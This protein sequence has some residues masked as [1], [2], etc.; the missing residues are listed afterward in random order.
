[1]V[2]SR[3]NR[4]YRKRAPKRRY[5]RL[6]RSPF[7][8]APMPNKLATKLRY[9]DYSTLDPGTAGLAAVQV[10]TANG[11]YDPD[12]S[13][14]GHQ[15][16]GFDQLMAMYDHYTVVSSKITVD[17]VTPV[18]TTVYSLC[19]GIALKDNSTPYG[20][21]NDYAEGRNV[22]SKILPSV[23][24]TDGGRVRTLSKTFSC[25]KFLGIASP[26]S[27]AYVR[28]DIASNPTEEAYFHLFAA[29]L[30]LVD[31]AFIRIQYRIEYNVVF[32]EP[33][34]PTQS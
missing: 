19:V 11:C 18:S 7:T 15:P 6:Y 30:G 28:G 2:K 9:V 4:K 25:R 24:S 34:Q 32:T 33:K 8:K 27:N 14:S 5:H 21:Y 29:P 16:R 1:M 17:F 13:G 3:T 12:I 10:I 26:L 31:S 20:N 22:I 23:T